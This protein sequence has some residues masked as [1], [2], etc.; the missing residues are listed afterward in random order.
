MFKCNDCG[1]EFEH[2]ARW[3]EY[4][5]EFWGQ[6]AYEIMYGCPFCESGDYYEINDDEN[7]DDKEREE[8]E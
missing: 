7:D 1:R 5:G 3:E 2:P 6:P 8:N 4:R